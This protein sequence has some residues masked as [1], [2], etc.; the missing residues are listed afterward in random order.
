MPLVNDSKAHLDDFEQSYW[1]H[2][3][4][5]V[6]NGWFLTRAGLALC[7]HGF[8]PGVHTRTASRSVNIAH[9]RFRKHYKIYLKQ[10]QARAERL[11]AAEKTAPKVT[12]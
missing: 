12:S 9:W 6:R 2:L 5:S 8:L 7:L 11:A 10:K 4:F 3:C 1:Y